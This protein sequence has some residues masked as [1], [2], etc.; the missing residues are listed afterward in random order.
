MYDGTLPREDSYYRRGSVNLQSV[1]SLVSDCL[2]SLDG[3]VKLWDIRGT[4]DAI[5]TI[6]LLPGGLS[7]FDVHSAS[8]VFA[9][10]VS[11]SFF[12]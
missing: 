10:L 12:V 1:L 7:A 11:Q 2:A 8:A 9:A 5:E 3:Q 4:D 6:D